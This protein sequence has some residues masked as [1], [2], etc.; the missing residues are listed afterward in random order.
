M[1]ATVVVNRDRKGRITYN[2]GRIYLR[3]R[4]SV[5]LFLE[6]AK[7]R[8]LEAYEIRL[9]QPLYEVTDRGDGYFC[10]YCGRWEYWVAQ[11]DSAKHCPVCGIS[12]HDYYVKGANGLWLQGMATKKAQKQKAKNRKRKEKENV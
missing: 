12:D 6:E 11:E 8:N 7:A 9:R 3:E 2:S 5:E 10:P 1:Y 4:H